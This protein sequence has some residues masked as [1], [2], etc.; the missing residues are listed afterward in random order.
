MRQIHARRGS[1]IQLDVLI[2]DV[3]VAPPLHVG[4]HDTRSGLVDVEEPQ[5]LLEGFAQP[6]LGALAGRVLGE[7]EGRNWR[8]AIGI[9]NDA[10]IPAQVRAA[11][12]ARVAGGVGADIRADGKTRAGSV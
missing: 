4:V 12:R 2:H 5:G 3:G 11:V 6:T 1:R 8:R 9:G 10:R 7:I